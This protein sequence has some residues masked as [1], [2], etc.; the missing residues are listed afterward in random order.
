MGNENRGWQTPLT[1]RLD[2]VLGNHLEDF[3]VQ[4]PS[5]DHDGGAVLLPVPTILLETPSCS[6]HYAYYKPCLGLHAL[7]TS[8]I[9]SS[10]YLYGA[11]D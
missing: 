7:L 1:E 10:Q 5:Y 4:T 6:R 9:W 11:N 8:R 2:G 3:Q